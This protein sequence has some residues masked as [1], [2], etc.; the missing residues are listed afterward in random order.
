MV[1]ANA[2]PRF[3]AAL[4]GR[5]Q[6]AIAFVQRRDGVSFGEACRILGA[7]PSE[8]GESVRAKP[9]TPAPIFAEDLEPTEDWRTR[10]AAFVEACETML[11]SDGGERAR[12][13][14]ASRGLEAETLRA[15]RVGFQTEERRYE[16]AKRWGI[17]GKDV[18]LP[19]GIVLP[20]LTH[21]AVWQLKVR[22]NARDPKERYKAVRGGHPLLYGMATLVPDEPAVMAEGE[23]DCI[24][25]WQY[26]KDRA[27]NAPLRP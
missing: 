15:W 8:L 10:A 1:S 12:A 7:S 6:D 2:G 9:A 22:T 17:D 27:A 26:L 13:Y 14:L 21:T 19:R 3:A 25:L 20:W 11:W 5:W 24:L 16:P 18:W 23:F 4:D